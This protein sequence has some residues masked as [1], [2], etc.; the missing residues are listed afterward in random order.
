MQPPD[1]SPTAYPDVNRVLWRLLGEVRDLLGPRLRGIYLY[2]SLALGDFTPERSDI[3]FVAVTDGELPPDLVEALGEMHA[4]LAR[5]EPPWGDELE[6]SYIPLHLLRRHDPEASLY[7][8]IERGESLRVERHET[9]GVIQRHLLR[10]HGITLI[11]PP[12][13]DWIDPVTREDLRREVATSAA[14]WLEPVG[15]DPLVLRHR[16]YQ[17]YTV[18]TICRMLYTLRHGTVVSK[19]VA[20]RWAMEELGER[21]SPLI[22]RALADDMDETRRFIDYALGRVRGDYPQGGMDGQDS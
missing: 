6:G 14:E 10:E 9:G 17:A 8:S 12:V 16:G 20:A 4:R 2:G 5:E 15:D 13:R 19:P 18:M 1:F 11:G 21:W 7:P 22:A 3:D